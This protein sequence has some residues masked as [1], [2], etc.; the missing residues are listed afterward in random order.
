MT[1]LESDMLGELEMRLGF[2][3][4]AIAKKVLAASYGNVTATD[5][6]SILDVTAGVAKSALRIREYFQDSGKA[7]A[8]KG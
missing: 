3:R 2:L 5:L 7:R 6:G 1:D 4:D 8:P